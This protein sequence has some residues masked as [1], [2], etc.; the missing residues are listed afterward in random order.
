LAC[1][2]ST[3]PLIFDINIICPICTFRLKK[4]N[5]AYILKL[6]PVH[7]WRERILILFNLNV[8]KENQEGN[9]SWRRGL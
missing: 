3:L 7:T 1:N 9:N 8:Q 4:Q 5:A 6:I 2:I